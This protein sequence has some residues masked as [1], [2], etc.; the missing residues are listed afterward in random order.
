M[1]Y[2]ALISRARPGPSPMLSKL[3]RIP[4]HLRTGALD[5]LS[6]GVLALSSVDSSRPAPDMSVLRARAEACVRD[7]QPLDIALSRHDGLLAAIGWA[8]LALGMTFIAAAAGAAW[9]QRSVFG[10]AV[11]LSAG[12]LGA[13]GLFGVLSALSERIGVAVEMAYDVLDLLPEEP[14]LAG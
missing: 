13:F 5:A 1:L 2:Q 14:S 8:L 10:D 9:V 11:S 12:A 7:V 6:S 4:T 3:R